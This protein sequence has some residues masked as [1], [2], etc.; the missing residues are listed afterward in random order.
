[1]SEWTEIDNK[2]QDPAWYT[3]QEYHQVFTRLRH[4]DPVHWAEDDAYG[5][6]YWFLTRYE[7][8]RNMLL[9]PRVF[10]SRWDTRPPKTTKRYTPEERFE[11]GFDVSMAR[12]DPPIHDL[13]RKPVNKHFSAPA[14][15]KMRGDVDAIND[16]IIARVAAKGRAD[17]VEEI[18]G[19]MP[20]K[21]ILR[22][23]GVPEKDWD[24]LRV[25]A[26]QWLAPAHPE[27]L[28]DGD[29][30]KTH[31]HGHSKLLDYCEQLA[32]ARREEPKDDFATV[33]SRVKVDG[34]PLSI[35]EMR[36]YFTI[37]IGGGLET[38]RNTAAVGLWLFLKNPDQRQLLLDDPSLMNSAIDEVLRWVS[39][40]RTRFRIA[41]EDVE[42]GGKEI[43]TGDWVFGS[44]VSANFDETVFENPEKFDITRNP[45]PHL[46]FGEGIHLCLG[47]YLARLELASLFPKVLETFPDMAIAEEPEWIPDNITTGFSKFDVTYTPVVTASH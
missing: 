12:N 25:A 45:N 17:V 39:P 16:E 37:M 24:M 7:D 33:L 32:L 31:R 9:N 43:R 27:Y 2:L 35:H 40:A 11:M 34:D 20:V 21:V 4:E 6:H 15:N 8:V 3:T 46:S 1:M 22:L 29:V 19:E 36:S 42:I 5:K 28:I 30:L 13:Y 18:A 14:I 26:W 23:L 44:Q 47:R 41:M 10:S 38:T